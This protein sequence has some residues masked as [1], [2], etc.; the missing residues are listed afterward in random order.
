MHADTKEA[1]YGEALSLSQ[2]Y[3]N[4]DDLAA[5]TFLNKYALRDNDQ[6][7]LEKRPQD[8]HR[9]I[10]KEFARIEKQ[11][12]KR[13]Y[14][15][16]EIY[17]ALQY[18]R[19]I[20]PQGSPMYGIGN[21]YQFISLSNCY[22]VEP[23]VDSYGGICKTDQQLVQI[24]KRRGGNGTDLSLLRPRKA[25][26]HNAARTS[27]GIG[28]FMERF[29]NSIREVGQEG[30]RGA[31]MLTLSVHHPEVETFATIKN[32]DKKVTGANISIRLTDEFLNAVLKDEEYEQRWPCTQADADKLKVPFRKV[33][34]MVKARDVWDTII[35]SAH[36]RAEPGLLFWDNII[37]ESIPDCYAHLG[38]ETVS[39][40]PCSEI[41]LSIL[42]SCR[43]LLLN[44]YGYV[45]NA[46]RSD[47]YFDWQLFY[48]DTQMAQ[49]LMDDLVDLELE[50]IDR[51]LSK[52]SSDP[53]ADDTKRVEVDLWQGIRKACIEGRRTGTGITALGD[54]MAALGIKYGSDAS[55]DFTDRVYKTLKFGAFRASVD[56]AKELG[57]FPIWDHELEKDNPFL[58]RI[59]EETVAL[60]QDEL[61][62][63]LISGQAL[64]NDMKKYGRRNIALLTTAPAGTVSI[65]T[66]TTSGIEPLFMIGYT[67]R[68]KIIGTEQNARVD[69]VDHLGDKWTE[70]TVYH[71]KVTEWMEV[72]GETDVTK[73]PWY[74]CCAEDLDWK[75]RVILQA[76]ANAHVDH[77]ISSTINL[78]EDV[79]IEKV[80][81][82][83]ETAWQY[84]CKGITV[85]R[86]N[87]RTGVLVEKKEEKK[88]EGD[89]I[90]KNHAPK[91]PKSLPCD[92][93]H[94]RVKGNEYFVLVGLF[95]NSKDPYEVFAGLN[96]HISKGVKSGVVE[97]LSRG[98]Y[99]A[100]F[101][102]GTEMKSVAEYIE[103][104]EEAL[105]R[106]IS[107][108]LRH[109]IDISYIVHQL[110]KT[111]GDLQSFSKAMARAL[112]KYIPDGSVV[113][114]ESCPDCKQASI[115]RGERV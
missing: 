5:S 3:F 104:S 109:G 71:P 106:S 92:V 115:V 103:D 46:F 11:K 39:T 87:C 18:F 20:V 23:P 31:L 62:G 74:G 19:R 22:V 45:R 80:K 77:A 48:S 43:L 102:D 108:S 86:K 38:F 79:S 50:C 69:F 75:Q 24:S 56:M 34:R 113:S 36:M 52:I 83:Y 91:R 54:T 28:P 40:N 47:A 82:I 100:S 2:T 88:D 65:M 55:I 81:E 64:W 85:Y 21:P 97:K 33:S 61:G 95:G 14:S 101:E 44:C 32:D 60:S 67:R 15:E 89:R 35:K 68:R 37:R 17:D 73:S 111:K 30:R 41:P 42:D 7:L 49:R 9:R 16:G 70:F 63:H 29:S 12:F 58:N 99:Y 84:G 4:G 93:H 25:P 27:T 26:T 112:K 98:V 76:K 114:G 13:P 72:T 51:I 105:T 96:G 94:I 110:E 59:R 8:M 57:P 78:P 53:E 90:V 10:A 1:I 6:N 66:Q 107:T